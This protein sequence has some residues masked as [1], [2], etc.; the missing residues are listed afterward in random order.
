MRKGCVVDVQALPAKARA[1]LTAIRRKKGGL[2]PPPPDRD[3]FSYRLTIKG[4][5]GEKTVH[6]NE[7]TI[8]LPARRLIAFLSSR[9]APAD[10]A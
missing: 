2:G 3:T 6:L 4:P 10:V 5:A 7:S 1:G 9:S 8:P